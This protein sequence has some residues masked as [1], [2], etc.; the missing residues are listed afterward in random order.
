MTLR[1][2]IFVAETEWIEHQIS[3][4]IKNVF[5]IRQGIYL[6][7]WISLKIFKQMFQIR[8]K[9]TKNTKK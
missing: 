9:Q 3:L 7:I 5:T 6:F 1:I 2:G 4:L 8:K